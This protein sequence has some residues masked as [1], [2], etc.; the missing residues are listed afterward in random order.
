MLATLANAQP[1]LHSLHT[2][3]T[4]L[5]TLRVLTFERQPNYLELGMKVKPEG[6]HA[7]RVLVGPGQAF[8]LIRIL[9]RRVV[10]L[11]PAVQTPQD[12]ERADPAALGCGV[13]EIRVDP[14]DLHAGVTEVKTRIQ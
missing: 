13:Q 6:V 2:V 10:N 7:H 9:K 5:G 3:A 4:L 12:F 1:T 8:R 14:K 11:M